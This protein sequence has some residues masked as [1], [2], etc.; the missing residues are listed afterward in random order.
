[1]ASDWIRRDLDF[2]AKRDELLAFLA[3][4]ENTIFVLATSLKNR[5]LARNVLVATDGLDLYAF[6]WQHSRK[7]LQIQQN[8]KVALCKDTVQIEGVAEILGGMLEER[9]RAALRIL[10]GRFPKVIEHWR[11]RPGMVLLHIRPT[12]AVIGN[13]AFEEPYL[14]VIDL[15][16]GRAYAE[17][18]AYR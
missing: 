8:P 10:R 13:S 2:A 1:M 18:W 12:L 6:T 16:R 11:E 4:E 5:V 3:S 17:R 9:N 7:V 14:E 15:E